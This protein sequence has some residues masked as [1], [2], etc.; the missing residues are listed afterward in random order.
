MLEILTDITEGKGKPDDLTRLLE[1]AE[2]VK[3]G[4]LCALGGT[5]PNPVLTTIKYFRPEYEAHI[6]KKECPARVCKALISF[7]IS[8]DKCTG[9]MACLNA[10]PVGAIKGEKKMVHII[11]QEGC[12]RCGICLDACPPKFKAIAKITGS[13]TQ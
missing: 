13:L 4:S 10:C 2:A 1:L 11:N 7:Y 5:A 8:P 12:I 6:N 9:C 3:I